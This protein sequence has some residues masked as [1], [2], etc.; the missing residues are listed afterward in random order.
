MLVVL[1][2]RYGEI[3][4]ACSTQG[5]DEKSLNIFG[6]ETVRK[7]TSGKTFA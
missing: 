4:Q 7:L 6:L 1:K 2:I 5:R 3:G